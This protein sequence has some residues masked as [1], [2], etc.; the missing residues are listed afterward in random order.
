MFAGKDNTVSVIIDGKKHFY[1]VN[2]ELYKAISSMEREDIGVIVKM[3]S[4]PAKWLRAGAVLNPGFW[5]LKNPI[6]DTFTAFVYSKYGFIPFLDTIK[7]TFDFIFRNETYNMWRMSGGE[8]SMLVSMDREYLQKSF[9]QVMGEK[10]PVDYVKNPLETLQIFAEF[11]ESGTRIG[12]FARGI[13]KGVSPIEAGFGS[14]EVSLD[15]AVMGA[16]TRSWNMIT[17]FFNSNMRGIDKLVREATQRPLNF[18]PKVLIGI[19]IPSILLYLANRDDDRYKE[20]PQWEKDIFWIFFVGDEIIRIPKPFEVGILFGSVPER[21]MEYQDTQDP[22]VLTG[23]W[24]SLVSS[25]NPGVIPTALVPILE[26]WANYS[27]FLERNIVPESEEGLPPELQYSIYTPEILKL[28]GDWLNYSPR[29]IENLLS[30]YTAGLGDLV[31]KGLDGILKNTGI[32]PDPVMPTPDL[33]DIPIIGALIARNP[34]GSGSASVTKFYDRLEELTSYEAA[35][36]QFIEQGNEAKYNDYL[37]DH[38]ETM[39]LFD[40]E[41]GSFY[42]ASARYLRT[43]SKE[44]SNLR[45]KQE[46]IYQS[47]ELNGDEKRNLIDEI[48]VLITDTARLALEYL[49]TMPDEFNE[50]GTSPAVI[51]KTNY[52]DFLSQLPKFL[53]DYMFAE[54]IEFGESVSAGYFESITSQA[55][56]DDVLID[57]YYSDTSGWKSGEKYDYRESNPE[58]DAA[59]NFWGRVSTLQSS[60]ALQ[61]LKSMANKYK[62]PYDA[63]PAIAKYGGTTTSTTTTT[64]GGGGTAPVITVPGLP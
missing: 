50:D 39:F 53:R 19:T 56:G 14:R 36:K 21:I 30:G 44:L 18:F 1:Q 48:D 37:K 61:L 22:S 40:Y 24:D 42:S 8:R 34:Y 38:P 45:N 17:A 31:I 25:M 4:Y 11:T 16:K 62:I 52:Y 47:S 54:S 27:F 13:R 29:K 20:L 12:E 7:G 57:K 26:N 59:L 41:A 58:I 28:L 23:V 32:L 2:P 46:E 3:M 49:E 5:L 15:F 10:G 43:V 9:K 55:E 33:K 6:R 60:K 51:D 35:L 64:T 63:F